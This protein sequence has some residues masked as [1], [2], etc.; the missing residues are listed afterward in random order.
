[1]YNFTRVGISEFKVRQ[2]PKQLITIGLGSCV[3]I[4]IYDSINKIGGLS[5]ILLPDSVGFNSS[6]KPGKFAD[7]A[8]PTMVEEIKGKNKNTRLI[9]KISGGA[10]MFFQSEDNEFGSIGKKNVEAVL[11]TLQNLGIPIIGE[12][13]GGIVGRTMMVNLENFEVTI[14]TIDKKIIIL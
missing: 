4:A 11:K 14:R 13:T 2:A 7:L 12:H 6:E 3:G 8:I 10:S 9:A 1:M 5:H